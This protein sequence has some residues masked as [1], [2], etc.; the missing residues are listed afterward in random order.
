[1]HNRIKRGRG[2]IADKAKVD[3]VR[4]L[5]GREGLGAKVTKQMN[6]QNL[7]SH[8][9][10]DV[11][12]LVSVCKVE[13]KVRCDAA[14][15]D[16]RAEQLTRWVIGD[17]WASIIPQIY[18]PLLRP[19]GTLSCARQSEWVSSFEQQQNESEERQRQGGWEMDVDEEAQLEAD[20]HA[21]GPSDPLQPNLDTFVAGARRFLGGAARSCVHFLDASM[22]HT[23]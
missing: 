12:K 19:D 20:I 16:G 10:S 6:L 8:V 1:M 7:V 23:H 11:L 21:A 18:L 5:A 15:A 22:L 13:S 17:R 2:T 4:K 9:L 3:E 14:T